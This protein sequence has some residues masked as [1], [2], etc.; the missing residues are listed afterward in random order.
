M[1]IFEFNKGNEHGRA[2]RDT[3]LEKEI[4]KLTYKTGIG[5]QFGGKV[6]V[7]FLILVSFYELLILYF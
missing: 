2:F 5:A 6:G 1:I 3:E 7:I 4:L